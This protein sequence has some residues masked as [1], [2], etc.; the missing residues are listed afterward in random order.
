MCRINL[1]KI[2]FPNPYLQEVMAEILTIITTLLST[3]MKRILYSLHH[4]N[5]NKLETDTFYGFIEHTLE[6]NT[7]QFTSHAQNRRTSL[8]K[9]HTREGSL[10]THSYNYIYINMDSESSQKKL[11]YATIFLHSCPSKLMWRRRKYLC[12][13]LYFESR[14]KVKTRSEGI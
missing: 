12:T 7:H 3:R 6:Y 10:N 9:I 2:Y 4:L 5:D 13:S 1:L 14:S 8:R 11:Y